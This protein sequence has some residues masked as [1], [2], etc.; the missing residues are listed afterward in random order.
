MKKPL[1]GSQTVKLLV[2]PSVD[3]N[4]WNDMT[5]GG[6]EFFSTS[7]FFFPKMLICQNWNC[8]WNTSKFSKQTVWLTQANIFSRLPVHKN[9]RHYDVFPWWKKL[10]IP[11]KFSCD[12]KTVFFPPLN[13]TQSIAEKLSKPYIYRN[14]H[15]Y[16][17]F[18]YL[19]LSAC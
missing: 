14:I 4:T 3:P 13:M 5:R 15:I 17:F 1:G 18:Y 6:W 7:H 8:S 12:G 2:I 16:V 10:S 11:Q 19:T 9:C